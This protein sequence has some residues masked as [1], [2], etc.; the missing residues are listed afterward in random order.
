MRFL[1]LPVFDSA[2]E[3][4]NY[5]IENINLAAQICFKERKPFSLHKHHK[6]L[7]WD[8]ECSSTIENRK[9]ILKIYRANP[10]IENYLEFKKI[11]AESKKFLKK[12]TKNSWISLLQQFKRLNTK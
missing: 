7:W 1:Q 8:E 5:L 10:T 6:P 12:K 2:Q 11:M 9:N 3:I 4:F